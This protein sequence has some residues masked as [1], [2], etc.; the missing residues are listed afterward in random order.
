[1]R[2]PIRRQLNGV[3]KSQ[4]RLLKLTLI[5]RELHPSWQERHCQW[6]NFVVGRQNVLENEN[7][8]DENRLSIETKCLVN[9]SVLIKVGEN[10]QHQ[11]QI[12]FGDHQIWHCVHQLPVSKLMTQ[13]SNYLVVGH[14]KRLWLLIA[15]LN[16]KLKQIKH[17]NQTSSGFSD[18]SSPSITS[19]VF[20]SVVG[21]GL[22][23]FFNCSFISGLSSVSNKTIRL[24]FQK[25]S[26]TIVA[27]R[28]LNW[29]IV[30]KIQ[31]STYTCTH[32]KTEHY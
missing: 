1:M 16:K 20:L 2:N 3:L 25:P 15:L 32:L 21:S 11:E 26:K 10:N 5:R 24:F 22:F 31:Q 19:S 27:K 17:L 14:S 7:Q 18:F 29:S 4:K 6:H 30:F 12:D 23:S 28:S 8:S 9:G 13:D